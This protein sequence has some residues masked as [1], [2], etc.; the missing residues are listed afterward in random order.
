M[1]RYAR[2]LK[3]YNF[4]DTSFTSLQAQPEAPAAFEKKLFELL[5]AERASAG[6]KP[7]AWDDAGWPWAA[8]GPAV[9]AAV[10]AGVPVLGANRPRSR[11][12]E[13]MGRTFAGTLDG[14]VGWTPSRVAAE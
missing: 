1:D 9:M 11:M 13:D 5:N 10:R 6:L 3:F 14:D 8:Y 4:S 2:R 7:L 12:R